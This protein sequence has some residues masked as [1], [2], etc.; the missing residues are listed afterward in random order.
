MGRIYLLDCTL[1]DG[2][3]VV[4]GKFGEPVMKGIL[5]KMQETNI[6]IVECG[7]LKNCDYER[8]TT[9]YHIPDDIEPYMPKKKENVTYVAMIDWDRYNTEYLSICNE[10]TIDA[11]RVVFPSGKYKQG[12]AV[13]KKIEKKGYRVFYQAANTLAYSDDDLKSLAEEL[14]ATNAESISVV[15][16]FG[17]MYEDDLERIVRVL[18]AE[19]KPEIKMGFHSHNNQQLSFALSIHFANMFRGRKRDIVIDA[20]LCGMGRGAG[21]ATTE[22]VANYLNLKFNK[23]YNMDA[24]M[25]AI[26]I[27]MS[28]FQENYSWGYST[29]YC[30]AGMYCCHV[31]NIM[32][33]LNNHRTNARDMRNIIAS[34]EPE[35][36]CKY[37]YDLLEMKYLDN[38]N[39]KIDDTETVQQIKQEIGLK[40]VLL[41]APGASSLTQKKCI[42][43][44]IM[45]EQP[46]VMGV[47]AILEGYVY[48]Y[49]FFVNSARYEY[50]KNMHTQNF[51]TEHKIL[52]SSIKREGTKNERII[53]YN[54]VIK[55]GWTHYDN[56]VICALR[57]M[58][59]LGV[60]K[61]FLAGFDGFKTKYNE[62]YADPYLPSLNPD[63][64][65]EELNEEIKDM[66]C[67][68]KQNKVHIEDICFV[69]DSIY[70]S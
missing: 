20:S 29:P 18:D 15:D 49:V 2:A 26:D 61:V 38:E 1:R 68:F 6:D 53:N 14:N 41:V 46:V 51:Q 69:T 67:D 45:Q 19:L 37:N 5:Q 65:W 36:R 10:H 58:D 24:I 59:R 40:S 4:D 35:D 13:G 25:D 56:A 12:I 66:F 43:T 54:S 31:N 57:L 55:R 42:E 32:Y 28:Y 34:M 70:N 50:A 9:F 44:L 7:W 52:L 48:D 64:Q 63:N 39:K 47:N 23:H 62:S 16:T 27:Y 8:G 17:A 60:K 11:I 3:Y 33:L 21:N 22:L 30:I